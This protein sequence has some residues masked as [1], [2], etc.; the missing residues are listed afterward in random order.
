MRCVQVYLDNGTESCR[1]F[2]FS[3]GASSPALS[4]A[5]LALD[6]LGIIEEDWNQTPAS[7]RAALRFLLH[8]L[9][10]VSDCPVADFRSIHSGSKFSASA[11]V[12]GDWKCIESNPPSR[13]TKPTV[14]LLINL[15]MNPSL[16]IRASG[17]RNAMKIFE[18]RRLTEQSKL[19]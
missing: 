11:L 12:S 5:M 19:F 8:G 15:L 14:N 2:R 18:L 1:Q 9:Q 3:S 6:Q 4:A 10:G 16:S 7:V 13:K 17:F